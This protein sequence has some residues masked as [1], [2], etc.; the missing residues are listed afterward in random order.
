M[1]RYDLECTSC[2]LVEE[3]LM[4][5][6][7]LS[8]CR[9]SDGVNGGVVYKL[10]RG[11]DACGE[12]KFVQNFSDPDRN[13]IDGQRPSM[14]GEGG[15]GK[16]HPGLG[17]IIHSYDEKNRELKK[18]GVIE[19]ADPIGGSRSVLGDSDKIEQHAFSPGA[20]ARENR[21]RKERAEERERQGFGW[22]H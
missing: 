1:P 10:D 9:R 4:P 12:S 6:S 21:E 15:T 20:K 8:R 11:C 17:K 7:Q 5:I 2:G 16:Y 13:F 22:A 3:R 14:Y 18:Q 19:A